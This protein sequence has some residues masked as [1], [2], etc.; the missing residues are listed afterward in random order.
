MNRLIFHLAKACEVFPGYSSRK[1]KP[2]H[3]HGTAGTH[4]GSNPDILSLAMSSFPRRWKIQMSSCIKSRTQ[5][6]GIKCISFYKDQLWSLLYNQLT[7][8]KKTLCFCKKLSFIALEE[9]I[10][11]EHNIDSTSAGVPPKTGLN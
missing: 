1:L 2:W 9:G 4:R 5:Y 6:N 7:T 11:V 10:Q 3:I 8:Q